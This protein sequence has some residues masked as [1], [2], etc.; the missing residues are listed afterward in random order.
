MNTAQMN[1]DAKI[2][3]AYLG[4]SSTIDLGL[5]FELEAD[6]VGQIIAYQRAAWMAE[7]NTRR[8]L[9][10]DGPNSTSN[11]TLTLPLP[12]AKLMRQSAWTTP[13]ILI[14]VLQVLTIGMLI[15][16]LAA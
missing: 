6:E 8:L 4:G 1:R 12:T 3:K 2:F 9:L 7:P 15:L 13:L 14:I 5:R 11:H 10:K 16:N